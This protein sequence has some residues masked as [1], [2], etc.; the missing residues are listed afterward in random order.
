[1]QEW[2]ERLQNC[3]SQ[4][5]S[6]VAM[7]PRVIVAAAINGRVRQIGGRSGRDRGARRSPATV[8]HRCVA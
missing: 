7:D 1:M 2:I 8:L 6:G 5:T 3:R 4:T